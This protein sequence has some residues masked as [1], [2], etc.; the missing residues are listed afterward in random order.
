MKLYTGT[1]GFSYKE[2]IGSFYPEKIKPADMLPYYAGQ[3][4]VVEINN[5]FYRMPK[6][7]VLEHWKKETPGGFL[8]SIKASQKITHRKRLLE[9]ESETDYLIENLGTLGDKLGALLFQFPP[10]FKK[11]S[12]RLSNFLKILPEDLPA[13][14]EFRDDSWHDDEITALLKERKFIYCFSDMDEKDPPK[15]I[16]TTDWGY[17]RLR[18]EDYS[19]KDL[20]NWAKVIKDQ[21]WKKAFVF[22]K[23]EDGGTGPKL[24]K[25]FEGIFG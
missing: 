3:L 19:S 8:F 9:A 23:H 25:D 12:E 20:I 2:W 10:F 17:L 22:F 1:S 24:A 18:R 16:S 15:I 6:K 4:K 7:E 5:T 13:V 21:G 11:D 14:F